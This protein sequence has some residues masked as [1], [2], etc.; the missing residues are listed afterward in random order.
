MT[1]AA[2]TDAGDTLTVLESLHPRD[3]G[4]LRDTNAGLRYGLVDFPV[5]LTE[6]YKYSRVHLEALDRAI[7]GSVISTLM[8]GLTFKG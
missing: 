1:F 6:M 5:R 3:A 7:P 8:L 2:Y 4:A